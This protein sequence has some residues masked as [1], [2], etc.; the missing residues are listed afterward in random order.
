MKMDRE[1]RKDDEKTERKAEK[2]ISEQGRREE[3]KDGGLEGRRR[4]EAAY[5]SRGEEQD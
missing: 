5:Q 1:G 2:G 3:H 4:S